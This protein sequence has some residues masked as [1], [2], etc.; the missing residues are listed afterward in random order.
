MDRVPTLTRSITVPIP[1]WT[2]RHHSSSSP[3]TNE[4]HGTAPPKE[5]P[6]RKQTSDVQY[7]RKKNSPGESIFMV[8]L[9][10]PS[11]F[12]LYTNKKRRN[13]E[14][15]PLRYPPRNHGRLA[16]IP[17]QGQDRDRE[18]SLPSTG[19]GATETNP[20]RAVNHDPHNHNRGHE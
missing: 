3:K 19:S 2:S 7:P 15:L 13:G 18:S 11:S 17:D 6:D 14:R 20:S 1:H 12:V 16:R 5:E 10:E 8:A 9:S 4:E